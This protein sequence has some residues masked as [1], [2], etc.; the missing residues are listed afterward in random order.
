MSTLSFRKR[1]STLLLRAIAYNITASPDRLDLKQSSDLL[2]SMSTLN[3]PD[4]NLLTRI[5]N[6]VC[7]ELESDVKKSSVIGSLI[8]SI[9]LLKYKNSGELNSNS[10]TNLHRYK[11]P[12]YDNI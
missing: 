3:F 1:R 12:F 8:T 10:C 7:I 4:D 2:Y 6:D 11:M 5:G 9:G